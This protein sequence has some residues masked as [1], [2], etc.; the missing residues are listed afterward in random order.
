MKDNSKL[1]MIDN[2]SEKQKQATARIKTSKQ[3]YADNQIH[4]YEKVFS[5]IIRNA[6][7]SVSVLPGVFHVRPEQKK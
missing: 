6:R 4:T 3:W 1:L 2:L 7:S 5:S